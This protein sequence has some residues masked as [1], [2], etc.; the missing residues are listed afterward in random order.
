LRCTAQNHKSLY[1]SIALQNFLLLPNCCLLPIDKTFLPYLLLP[2]SAQTFKRTSL[3]ST[4]MRWRFL[5]ST[6]EW[7]HVI[8]VVLWMTHFTWHYYLS[9]IHAVVNDSIS[10]PLTLNTILQCIS[11][12]SFFIHWLV[13][14]HLD[15]FI[16]LTFLNSAA[17]NMECTCPFDRLISLSSDLYSV[18]GSLENM[19]LYI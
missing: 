17:I 15:C 5:Y 13:N 10:F 16:F 18:L 14:G 9:F 3:F 8:L 2:Y 12:T 6:Y 11:T 7:D 19:Y 4:S 1:R